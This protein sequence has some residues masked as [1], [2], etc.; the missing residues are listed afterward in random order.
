[1][2]R[3]RCLKAR[4]IR[5]ATPNSLLLDHPVVAVAAEISALS[6]LPPQLPTLIVDSN[7]LTFKCNCD[8]STKRGLT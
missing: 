7:G 1:M 5:P 6:S 8:S 4:R 3:T 2:R